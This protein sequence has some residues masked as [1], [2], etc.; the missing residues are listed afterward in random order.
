MTDGLSTFDPNSLWPQALPEAGDPQSISPPLAHS[1]ALVLA[2]QHRQL[3]RFS[4]AGTRPEACVSPRADN[5]FARHRQ[6]PIRLGEPHG[7]PDR[8]L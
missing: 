2:Q 6:Q 4:L 7:V 8:K 3:A 1:A 5:H